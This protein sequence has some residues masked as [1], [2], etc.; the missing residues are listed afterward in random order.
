MIGPDPAAE[1]AKVDATIASIHATLRERGPDDLDR[2]ALLYDLGVRE[3]VRFVITSARE[4][5][6]AAISDLEAAAAVMPH[7]NPDRPM[8]LVTLAGALGDRFERTNQPADLEAS[9]RVTQAAIDT[10][11]ADH[12]ARPALIALLAAGLQVRYDRQADRGT[13]DTAISQLQAAAD[14]VG[15]TGFMRAAIFSNLGMALLDR[16][17]RTLVLTDLD[18]AIRYNRAALADCPPGHPERAGILNGLGMALV[19]RFQHTGALSDADDA[20]KALQT[21]AEAMTPGYPNRAGCYSNLAVVLLNRYLRTGDQVDLDAAVEAGQVAVGSCDRTDPRWAGMAANLA[22]ALHSR[23][24]RTNSPADLEEAVAVARASVAATTHGPSGYAIPQTN[25]GVVLHARFE[26]TGDATDLDGAI[27][28]LYESLNATPADHVDRADIMANV[29]VALRSRFE[30]TGLSTDRD[31]ALGAFVAVTDVTTARPSV[32]ALAFIAAAR[33]AGQADD[34]AQAAGLLTQAVSLLAEVAPRQLARGDRQHAVA[35]FAG[36]SGAAAA[37]ALA[38]PSLPKQDRP[39]RALALLEASRGIL[40]SQALATRDDLTD[41]W[42]D[43]RDLTRRFVDLRNQ[44]DQMTQPVRLP[45]DPLATLGL[46]AAERD[47]VAENFAQALRDIRSIGDFRNFGLP[48]SIDDL[49]AEAA[50]GPVVAFTIGARSGGALLLTGAG[51]GYLDLPGLRDDEVTAR[52]SSFHA[53]LRNAHSGDK[54]TAQDARHT[55]TQTL[56]WLWITAAGPVLDALGYRL[57][58]AD[59]DLWPRVWWVPGGKLGL[60]PMH[61]AGYHGQHI[62]PG[63]PARSVLDAVI[64]SYTPTV[65]AL[66]YARQQARH[67][68]GPGRAL[69]VAMPVTPR[70][71]D[72]P[73]AGKEAAVA[74]AVL[75]NPIVLAGPASGAGQEPA[76]NLP[77]R[78]NVL[79]HLPACTIAHFACHADSDATDPS[80]SLLLL[81]D[82]ETSPLTVAALAPVDHERLELTYLSAC[83]TAFTAATELADEAIHLTSAFLLA[84]SRHV[85]G[86]LWPVDDLLALSVATA[87]YADLCPGTAAGSKIDT[88]RAALALHNAVRAVRDQ[89][90]GHPLLW[91]PYLHAGA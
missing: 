71:Q 91:A 75:P 86:T 8:L 87:F 55:L 70:Q 85:V 81:D 42:R 29:G 44:L 23:S 61:A 14:A 54:Q 21:A 65:R 47:Q 63:A 33:L 59:G 78:E 45:D 50:D 82:Y 52:V 5:H 1:L 20:V 56:E 53:A 19:R 69:V 10:T 89:W 39:A 74:S 68:D 32:R 72:L 2:G 12:P 51:I 28:A 6:D 16:F 76:D 24:V 84:G 48:P 3:M 9:F 25:L 58:P 37:A 90:P 67:R 60:L 46:H 62:S 88:D 7:D 64:S 17:E 4:D 13:L 27:L 15:E 57:R 35:G 34:P 43:H 30:V 18:A 80:R 11:P 77:T 38:D 22:L 31:A 79:R 73:G 26:R 49:L 41:L 66:R 36:V 40:L 83:S